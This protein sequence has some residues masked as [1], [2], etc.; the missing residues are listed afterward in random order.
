MLGNIPRSNLGIQ[1]RSH[2]SSH[3]HAKNSPALVRVHAA[4]RARPFLIMPPHRQKTWF[5]CNTLKTAFVILVYTM[6][7]LL[8]DLHLLNHDSE[9]SP[10]SIIGEVAP[11]TRKV[12]GDIISV[13]ASKLTATIIV[14]LIEH[15][16]ISKFCGRVY[17]YTEEGDSNRSMAGLLL[18]EFKGDGNASSSSVPN[19]SGLLAEHVGR[20]TLKANVKEEKA[21][22]EQPALSVGRVSWITGS[23]WTAFYPDV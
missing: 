6:I 22:D 21:E 16:S 19:V 8:M 2:L 12:T 23:N 18:A 7:S 9:L 5:L 17:A 10:I 4:T 20:E 14:L 15:I 1:L 13:V 3:V 11:E